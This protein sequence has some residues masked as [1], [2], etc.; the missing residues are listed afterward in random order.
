MTFDGVAVATAPG[1]VMTPRPTSEQ[2]VA[3]A[4]RC[5]G[6]RTA[7]VADVGTGSGALA[8]AVA[9]RCPQ[10]DVWATD[11]SP[12][13][14]LIARANVRRHGLDGRVFVRNGDL[15]DPLPG[16]F[17]VIVAN[18]PYVAAGA[19]ADHPELV[20]E[21]FDA[22]FAAGDGL[23]PYRRLVAAASDRLVGGGVLVL[24][25][26]RRVVAARRTD[27]RALAAVLGSVGGAGSGGGLPA[28]EAAA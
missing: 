16:R 1:R 17:D 13:A 28:L 4:W 21:P 2:L 6:E 8:V 3:A 19:A 5:L 20:G 24:Q 9:K 22:V 10:A 27:L 26:H 23:D 7:R 12:A 15:L 25:L 11:T 14:C 18:L